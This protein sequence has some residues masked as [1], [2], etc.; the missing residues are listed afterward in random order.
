MSL[1]AAPLSRWL[2]TNQVCG[3]VETAVAPRERQITN[4]CYSPGIFLKMHRALT[5]ITSDPIINARRIDLNR[6]IS[7]LVIHPSLIP[8]P[9]A[10]VTKTAQ[11]GGQKFLLFLRTCVPPSDVVD[12]LVSMYSMSGQSSLWFAYFV[13]T[14]PTASSPTLDVS[15]PSSVMAYFSAAWR[16]ISRF[17]T[18]LTG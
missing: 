10:L 8:K 11:L 14:N 15:G 6:P 16:L 2:P 4:R 17:W 18:T 13:L 1:L 9:K 3:N 7:H 12:E 5:K